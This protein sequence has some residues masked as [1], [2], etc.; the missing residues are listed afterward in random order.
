M[1]SYVSLHTLKTL[2]TTY[3]LGSAISVSPLYSMNFK[4]LD[5]NLSKPLSNDFNLRTLTSICLTT[6]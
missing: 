6:R 2:W 3:T 1:K 4:G 5:A